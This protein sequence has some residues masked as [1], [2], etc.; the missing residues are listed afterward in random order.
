M[1]VLPHFKQLAII[2]IGVALAL[3]EESRRSLEKHFPL[4]DLVAFIEDIFSPE[5]LLVVN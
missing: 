1:T 4:L 2:V 3:L 5:N